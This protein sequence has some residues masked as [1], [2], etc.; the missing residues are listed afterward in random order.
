MR[1]LLA[2]VLVLS[3]SGALRSAPPL[4]NVDTAHLTAVPSMSTVDRTGKASLHLDIEPKPKMHVYAPGEKDQISVDITLD[5]TSAIK[6][7]KTVFP[8]PEKYFFPPLK[9]TQL[10]YS[11]PFRLT[12]PVTFT[13]VPAD[14][15]VT[16]KG[17]LTYQ[18]CD[19]AVCYVPKKV[20]VTWTLNP[21]ALLR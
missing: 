10:V 1:P 20:P 15:A 13:K 4:Q 6:A 7:G 3:V 16:I 19:D 17:T 9:L 12:V 14:G 5:R 18:A 21:G 11:K 2:V 8:Q